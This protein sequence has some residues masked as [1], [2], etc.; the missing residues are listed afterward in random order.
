MEK[1]PLA[2]LLLP[3]LSPLPFSASLPFRY[4][5]DVLTLYY[6]LLPYLRPSCLPTPHDRLR[7]YRG[8]QHRAQRALN[9][10]SRTLGGHC[11]PSSLTRGQRPGWNALTHQ[12]APRPPGV[13]RT[14][15]SRRPRAHHVTR[16]PRGALLASH[17]RSAR[18][19]CS[20]SVQRGT[21]REGAGRG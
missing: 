21:A 5:S 15:T 4:T 20:L 13:T 1:Q 17:G 16:T 14:R 2:L 9:G 8:S 12:P 19:Q 3:F 11:P 6:T 7:L 10:G 18:G